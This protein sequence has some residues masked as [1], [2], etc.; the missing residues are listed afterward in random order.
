MIR[1]VAKQRLWALF[2][3]VLVGSTGE[4]KAQSNPWSPLQTTVPMTV[5]TLP[6]A[7]IQFPDGTDAL[8]LTV[9]P[10]TPTL[11]AAGLRFIVRGNSLAWITVKPDAFIQVNHY[12]LGTT[13]FGSRYLGKAELPGGDL[14]GYN[15]QVE[16][17]IGDFRALPG[18]DGVGTPINPVNMPAAGG[19]VSGY[20]HLLA[21][22][23]WTPNGGMPA[24]GDYVGDVI[25]TVGA[26]PL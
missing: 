5:T 10:A 13:D 8:H 25:V 26:D 4:P 6:M 23:R 16:F 24:V 17:P 12:V 3:L 18:T 7:E 20:V 9:P 2:I 21:S 22:H 14:I 11:P 1:S 15:L 19:E